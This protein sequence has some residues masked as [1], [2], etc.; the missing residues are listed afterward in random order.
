MTPAPWSVRAACRAARRGSRG[1]P[2]AAQQYARA[3]RF[4][5]HA[6]PELVGELSDHRAYAC[7]LSGEFP[8]AIDAQSDALQHHRGVEDWLR[9]GQAARSLSLLLRYQGEVARAWEVGRK[10]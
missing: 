4:A 2:Q 3:L 5:Q 8:E 9:A 10:P 7:Y 1:A 6:A